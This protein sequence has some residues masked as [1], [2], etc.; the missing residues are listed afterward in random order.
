MII[1]YILLF[2]FLVIWDASGATIKRRKKK[3]IAHR[4]RPPGR[5]LFMSSRP[6]GSRWDLF[7]LR[8]SLFQLGRLGP[9]SC[10]ASPARSDPWPPAPASLGRDPGPA[11]ALHHLPA[12]GAVSSCTPARARPPAPP[13]VTPPGSAIGPPSILSPLPR[14]KANRPG[15]SR[16]GFFFRPP[17]ADFLASGQIFAGGQ[18]FLQRSKFRS[19]VKI[20]PLGQNLSSSTSSTTTS[21]YFSSRAAGS[22]GAFSAAP[23]RRVTSCLSV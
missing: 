7:R 2:P 14:P 4:P 1:L 3:K 22:T 9:S 18:N 16:S 15:Q 23:G 10:T 13:A 20:L 17:Q 21:A 5:G 8:L 6:S 11:S 12:L 19:R